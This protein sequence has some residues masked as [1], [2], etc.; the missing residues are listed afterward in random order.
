MLLARFLSKLFTKEGIV[1]IDSQGQ[2][3]ICGELYDKDKPLTLKLLKKDLN[4]KLLIYPELYLGEEYFKGNIEIINGSIHDFL[5]LTFK[6]IDRGKIN[7]LGY[8]VRRIFHAWRFITNYNLPGRAKVNAQFHYDIGEEK[9]ESLYDLFLDKKHRQYSCA[10][11]LKDDESLENA[12][13]NKINHIIK[14]LN[15]KAEQRILDIGC[16]WGGLAFEIARQSQCEVTGISLSKNQIEY[17][18]RKAKELKLDNQVSFELCDYRQVK[19]QFDRVVTVGFMEHLGR[20]FHKTFFK[21]LNKLMTD[22]GI[23]LCHTIGSINPPGPVQPFIQKHIFKGGVVPSLSELIKP[24]E[25]N[26]LI[27]G[28]I[29]FIIK[30]YDKTLKIWLER[31]L[32]NKEKVKFLY[33]KEFVRMWEFYLA[34]CSATFKFRDLVVF[35]LQIIKNFG[36]LPSNRRDYIYSNN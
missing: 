14:K 19:D 24:I 21:T 25:S 18:K 32:K 8:I 30:H 22:N 31:F 12:Q 11:F 20:K 36:A 33:N 6:N 3:Y 10:Y 2:K 9:G 23:A 17:C 5:N 35:Q 29:E 27:L 13:Q 28:D 16:G 1:L 7:T 34:S 15:L 26:G 4:W